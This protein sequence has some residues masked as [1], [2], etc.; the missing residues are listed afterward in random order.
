MNSKKWQDLLQNIQKQLFRIPRED[1]PLAVI[2][3]HL[4]F[5]KQRFESP[6]DPRAKVA[7]MLL[8]LATRRGVLA[9]AEYAVASNMQNNCENQQD[10]GGVLEDL[11]IS[12]SFLE[13]LGRF[14][15]Q[16]WRL[17]LFQVGS[18]SFQSGLLQDL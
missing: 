7:F 5:A 4:S 10:A 16:S 3:K 15:E 18:K 12:K 14:L 9:A 8:P 11:G 17:K 6:A 1:Q 13:S 2:F